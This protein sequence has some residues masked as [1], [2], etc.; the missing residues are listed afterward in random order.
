MTDLFDKDYK[1]AQDYCNRLK[2]QMAEIRMNKSGTGVTSQ[3][4]LMKATYNTLQ[5][6]VQHFDKLV[7]EYENEPGKYPTVS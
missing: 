4:Y 1:Q 7:Y 6:S 2:N 5:T 3:K